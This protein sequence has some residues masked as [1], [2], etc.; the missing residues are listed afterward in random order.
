MDSILVSLY[1]II[2]N[3]LKMLYDAAEIY[4]NL[5]LNHL[6]AEES[7]FASGLRRLSAQ[8][9]DHTKTSFQKSKSL[10]RF[11]K[12]LVMLIKVEASCKRSDI[13]N[14]KINQANLLNEEVGIS[15]EISESLSVDAKDHRTISNIYSHASLKSII[16]DYFH[17]VLLK[18]TLEEISQVC[19]PPYARISDSIYITIHSLSLYS[20]HY[21]RRR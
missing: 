18:F 16:W 14:V 12:G 9:D 3:D 21:G 20:S 13:E 4:Y 1:R 2:D 17:G 5:K 7:I 8:K 11:A 10:S 19:T 6:D 15:C